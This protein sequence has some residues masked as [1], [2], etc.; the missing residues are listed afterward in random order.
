MWIVV[1]K[2]N[3]VLR[4]FRHRATQRTA[5]REREERT[6]QEIDRWL[7]SAP[8]QSAKFE[9]R[10]RESPREGRESNK[11][12]ISA[13]E[14]HGSWASLLSYA[15]STPQRTVHLLLAAVLAVVFSASFRQPV[16]FP[17]LLL[18]R[19]TSQS[20]AIDAPANGRRRTILNHREK[21]SRTVYTETRRPGDALS[22]KLFARIVFPISFFL[23]R[24][25]RLV[26][27][28]E[29]HFFYTHIFFF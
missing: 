18:S 28:E 10:T 15:V 4:V 2:L 27:Y 6:R 13:R 21:I 11:G 17:T 29:M 5:C 9:F 25:M 1:E 7:S 14:V 19:P 16:A 3:E 23:L 24:V 22:G 12:V 26:R 20:K 8:K